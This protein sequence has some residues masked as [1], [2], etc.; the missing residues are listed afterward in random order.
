M[1]L[2]TFTREM[3]PEKER[4]I[5]TITLINYFLQTMSF[6]QKKCISTPPPQTNTHTRTRI[7]NQ[8]KKKKNSDR[9]MNEANAF[10]AIFK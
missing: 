10:S 5:K 1:I 4:V 2:V 3:K 7:T 9:E 6:Q 8:K